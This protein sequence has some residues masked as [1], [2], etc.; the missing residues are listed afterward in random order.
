M[1]ENKLVLLTLKMHSVMEQYLLSLR[2]FEKISTKMN[3]SINFQ[4]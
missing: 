2:F 1:S 3:F 4:F